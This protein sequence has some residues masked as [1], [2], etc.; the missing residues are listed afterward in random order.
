MGKSNTS[1]LIEMSEK[2]GKLETLPGYVKS[3][4]KRLETH[5]KTLVE[6]KHKVEGLSLSTL[7]FNFIVHCRQIWLGKKNGKGNI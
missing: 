5:E 2:L 3:I 4:D 7:L 1:Y 6:L